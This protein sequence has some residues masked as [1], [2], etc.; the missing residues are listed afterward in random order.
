MK[1]WIFILGCALVAQFVL[2]GLQSDELRRQDTVLK[3]LSGESDNA[4]KA[5]EQAQRDD[6]MRLIAE[7]YPPPKPKPVSQATPELFPK[8][9]EVTYP[10]KQGTPIFDR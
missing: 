9:E 8:V 3:R 1:A 10:L 4:Q 7:K 5:R 2:L 6:V